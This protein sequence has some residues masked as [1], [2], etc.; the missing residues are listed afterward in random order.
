MKQTLSMSYNTTTMWKGLMQRNQLWAGR[1]GAM[2]RE[3]ADAKRTLSS[4]RNC[5]SVTASQY[6]GASTSTRV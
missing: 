4:S 3:S 1:S 5:T 2:E 6:C